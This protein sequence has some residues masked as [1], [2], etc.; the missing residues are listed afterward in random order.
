M[1]SVLLILH[2]L[3]HVKEISATNFSLY[4]EKNLELGEQGHVDSFIL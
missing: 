4:I 3:L 1:S 2:K